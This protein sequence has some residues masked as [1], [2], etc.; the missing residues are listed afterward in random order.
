MLYLRCEQLYTQNS[1][2]NIC[3]C[4]ETFLLWTKIHIL[5]KLCELRNNN[6]TS[7]MHQFTS[8]SYMISKS[9]FIKITI[10]GTLVSFLTITM[11]LRYFISHLKIKVSSS[12]TFNTL[13]EFKLLMLLKRNA[14][15]S[16]IQQSGKNGWQSM[17]D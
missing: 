11:E 3:P 12:S 10:I 5:F 6:I 1:R 14:F 15:A 9:T 2:G 7:R 13:H 8:K 16:Y 17:I 4:C